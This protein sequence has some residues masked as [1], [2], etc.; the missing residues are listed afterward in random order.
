M[1]NT[2]IV[3]RAPIACTLIEY[4]QQPK[5]KS[6][7][8]LIQYTNR[9]FELTMLFHLKLEKSFYIYPADFLLESILAFNIFLPANQDFF[10]PAGFLWRNT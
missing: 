1:Q 3:K 5:W 4:R 6:F 8:Q 2:G 10:N 7:F 9:T